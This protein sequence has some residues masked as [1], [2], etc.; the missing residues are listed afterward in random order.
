MPN[1]RLRTGLVLA[2]A[3]V[4]TLSGCGGGDG[5]AED[6]AASTPQ[7]VAATVA[8]AATPA[9]TPKPTPKPVA[10]KAAKAKPKS[11]PAAAPAGTVMLT[12]KNFVFSP[13]VLTVKVGQTIDVVN[14]DSAPHTVTADDGSFDSG[15]LEQGQHYTFTIKTAGTFTYICDI[16]QYM[17]GTIK[18]T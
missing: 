4:A 7:V 6:A 9:P 14:L 12:I 18:V 8:P 15:T 11:T 1:R 2:V 3:L 5:A 13:N 17:T 10:T 16:H